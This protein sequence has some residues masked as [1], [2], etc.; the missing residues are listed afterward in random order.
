MWGDLSEYRLGRQRTWNVRLGRAGV[1]PRVRFTA[2]MPS[3]GA[4]RCGLG[5]PPRGDAGA[6][7]RCGRRAAAARRPARRPAHALNESLST[8]GELEWSGGRLAAG[9]FTQGQD[10]LITVRDA[11]AGFSPVCQPGCNVS[12]ARIAGG[13]VALATPI[14]NPGGDGD[15]RDVR[16]DVLRLKDGALEYSVTARNT[17]LFD[18]DLQE[19]G[20]V[21]WLETGDLGRATATG[22]PLLGLSGRAD[23]ACPRRGRRRRGAAGP[24]RRG[25][26]GVRPG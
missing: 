26:G 25:T 2:R 24:A 5:D 10:A 12:A 22:K 18:F 17:I 15:H 7:Q 21:A 14:F 6:R 9:E 3:L 20:K 19:D 16:I 4:R 1:R 13:R 23:A 8:Q 11:A